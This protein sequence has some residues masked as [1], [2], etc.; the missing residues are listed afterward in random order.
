MRKSIIQF[1]MQFMHK[2]SCEFFIK[3][4]FRKYID[5]KLLSAFDMNFFYL[6][7]LNATPTPMYIS[8]T[9]KLLR[10]HK[11]VKHFFSSRPC[12]LAYNFNENVLQPKQG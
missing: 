3:L 6:S 1:N 10:K 2:E 5:K 12:T 7:G 8:S 9:F 4:N 11:T